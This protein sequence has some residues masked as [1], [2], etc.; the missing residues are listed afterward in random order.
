MATHYHRGLATCFTLAL[1]R[2]QSRATLARPSHGLVSAHS[3]VKVRQHAHVTR[4]LTKALI[5]RPQRH[6]GGYDDAR[7]ECH[8]DNTEAP[9]PPA[10]APPKPSTDASNTYAAPP[11]GFETSPTTSPEHSS[12]QEDSDP[13]YTL[14]YEDP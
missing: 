13:S 8:I 2:Q 11:S 4:G 9:P 6:A 14:N 3:S 7:Q 5:A 12:K 1:A 10:M